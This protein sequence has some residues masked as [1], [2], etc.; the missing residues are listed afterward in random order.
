MIALLL[1]LQ[2]ATAAPLPLG[3]IGKQALPAKGCAAFLWSPAD[4]TLIAMATADPARLRLSID[5]RETDVPLVAAQGP[6]GFGFSGSTQYRAGD[7]TATLDLTIAERADLTAGAAIPS[8]T[9]RLER[10]GKDMVVMPLAGL[11]G[12]TG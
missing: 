1:A 8:A 4:R 7:V 10:V 6:G 3:P 9:L 2:L 5:G 12:C 11:I